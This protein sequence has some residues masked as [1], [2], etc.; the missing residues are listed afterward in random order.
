MSNTA[1]NVDRLPLNQRLAYELHEENDQKIVLVVS[2]GL[3]GL[4]LTKNGL[5]E[6]ESA[7]RPHLNRLAREGACGRITHVAPGIT[8]GS[9]PGHLALFGYDPFFYRIGRGVVEA[10]GSPYIPKRG[11]VLF[12][13]NFVTRIPSGIVTS[14]KAS[15]IG[16]DE[17]APLV[18]CLKAI[19]LSDPEVQLVVEP[20]PDH[21]FLLVLRGPELGDAVCDTDPLKDGNVPLRAAA[22]DSDDEASCR[23]AACVR[24][25]VEQAE[26]LLADHPK[27]NG[28]V[29][30]GCSKLPDDWPTFP[31][32][33]GLRAAA[34]AAYPMY[35]GLARLLGMDT[36]G[37]PSKLEDEIQLLESH[38]EKYDFHFVHFKTTD[39]EGEFGRFEK[40][41]KAIEY[42]DRLLPRLLD[43][44]PSVLI[45]TADHST[46]ATYQ[47]HSWHPVPMVLAA[48]TCCPDTCTSFGE[49][50]ARR[51]G[52]GDIQ[53]TD[54]MLVAL[55][56]AG[57]LRKFE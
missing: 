16:T 28:V 34:Y 10:L 24:E 52:I 17:A 46:P 20:L 56:H 36:I 50:E 51:G 11:E 9:G 48:G 4:P 27:G 18:E 21:R 37:D 33:Y 42:L 57:R 31:A 6:L 44:D 22:L 26:P 12:R 49:R 40:K 8:P 55:G 7:D 45:V 30:R 29:L 35:R 3:G 32:L 41:V 23:T 38:W 39:R 1:K 15:G 5:T 14:R 47:A 43:L 53:A 25:F 13:G 2:D 54:L 19:Q